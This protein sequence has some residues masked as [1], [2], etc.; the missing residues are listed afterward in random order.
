MLAERMEDHLQTLFGLLA[1]LY[2][3]HDVWAAHRSLLSGKRIHR[4]HALE[5]LENRL[6]GAVRRSVFAVIG[7]VTVKEKLRMAAREFGVPQ[8][9]LE[10]VLERLLDEG[11]NGDADAKALS[12]AALY[13]VYTDQ[14]TE[15]FPLVSS[16]LEGSRDSLVRETAA[17]VKERVGQPISPS[18]G[19]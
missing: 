2:P 11:R 6:T 14:L 10:K 8:L 12:V 18:S 17:W 9:S 3:P 15:V 16:L 1:I 19:R 7:D 13:T 5:Y 4:T